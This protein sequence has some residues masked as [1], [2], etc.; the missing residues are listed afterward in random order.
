MRPRAR[1]GAPRGG[2]AGR[3]L[4][5]LAGLALAWYGAMVALLAAKADPATVD[6][7]SG[8][9]TAYDWLAALRPQDVDGT[10]VR[11]ACGAGGA[12][13]AVLALVA[14]RRELP[15]PALVTRPLA[16][17]VAGPGATSVRPRAVER[18]AEVAAGGVA[19]VTGAGGHLDPDHGLDVHVR[20]RDAEAVPATLRAA[21][22]A[23]DDALAAHGLHDV[24][25]RL[26]LT[27]FDPKEPLR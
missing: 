11:I 1:L 8:L 21:R 7:L 17:D 4:V 26:T 3:A 18:I 24:P 9:R 20:V 15:R 14:L 10:T 6:G 12:V 2:L 13:V 5:L 19:R 16:L 22:A 25:V 23:V 27:R